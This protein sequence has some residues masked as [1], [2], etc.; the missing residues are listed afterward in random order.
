MWVRTKLRIN[1]I[2]LSRGAM[3]CLGGMGRQK[4]NAEIENYWGQEDDGIVAY[5]VRSGFD[6]LLQAMDLEPDDEILFSALNVKGMIA[7]ARREGFQPV[8]VDLDLEHMAP[9]MEALKKAIT[10][11]SKV[12]VVAHLFGTV[13]DFDPIIELAHKHGIIVVEDCA[14][15]FFGRNFKGHDKSDV[16]LFSFGPLKSTTALGG[17]IVRVADKNLRQRMRDIQAKYI[18]QTNKDQF[19][20]VLKF[21]VVKAITMRGCLAIVHRVLK[22]RGQTFDD[23]LANPIRNIAKLGSSKKLRFQPSTGMLRLLAYRLRN[24]N[25]AELDRRTVKG[26]TLSSLIGTSMVQPAAGNKAHSY[27]VFPV[28]SDH[29]GEFISSL[30]AQGFDA[31]DLPRSRAV[32]A[33]DDRPEL[34]PKTA[35]EIMKN[36]VIL[37]CYPDMSDSEIARLATCVKEAAK[38]S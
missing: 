17:A 14:Q 6:L 27:W 26:A 18:T 28:V 8:P 25:E 4:A 29:P 21:S 1:W 19:V 16:C 24:F 5:S 13:V 10:K 7:I 36:L 31:A 38:I 11:R 23:L 37:P 2:E 35:E 32:A 20:R 33:P 30:R 9:Q 22:A 3:V 34:H 15:A 12:L